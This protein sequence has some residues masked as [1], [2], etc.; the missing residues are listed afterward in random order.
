MGLVCLLSTVSNGSLL[1]VIVRQRSKSAG[2]GSSFTR[3]LFLL[4]ASD[5]TH[6]WAIVVCLWFV[7]Q[8]ET[9]GVLTC[10]YILG[11]FIVALNYSVASMLVMSADRLLSVVTPIWWANESLY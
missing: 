8:K 9:V 5:F 3:L 11:V 2:N 10:Y 7:W 1:W 6:S 4:T